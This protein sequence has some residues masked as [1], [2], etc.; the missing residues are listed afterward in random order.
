MRPILPLL[1]LALAA[2]LAAVDPGLMDLAGPETNFVLGVRVSAIADSPLVKDM[3]AKT[4]EGEAGVGGL[5]EAMG[6]NPLEDLE[7]LL[8]LGRMDPGQSNEEMDGLLLARGNFADDRV[9]K[10][11]CSDGCTEENYSGAQLFHGKHE[12]EEAT[13][14]K[15]SN[16]YAAA[17]KVERV[18]ALLQR[19]ATGAKPQLASELNDWVRGLDKHHLWLAAKGP[20]EAPSSEGGGPP[21]GQMVEKLTG[22]GLGITLGDDVELGLQVQ[23]ESEEAATELHT[24]TQGLL[25]LFTMGGQQEGSEPN[26][27]AALLESLQLRREGGRVLANLRIPAEQL[28]K[29]VRSGMAGDAEAEEQDASG[30]STGFGAVKPA[31]PQTGPVT[32]AKP[33]S[34][35]PIR[36]YGLGDEPIEVETQKPQ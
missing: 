17:G 8:L 4:A 10:A 3:L 15:L 32:P 33:R 30:A 27:A 35:G 25:M 19:R 2:P 7:E 12:G 36:I 11:F 22:L 24:M 13:F 20:F 1:L 31:K 18:K 23:A 6:D 5:L 28:E 21:I 14:V 26:E 29:T 34:K 9:R 16:R